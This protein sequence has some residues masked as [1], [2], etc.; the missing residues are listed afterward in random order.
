MDRSD[1]ILL[2]IREELA[3]IREELKAHH[4]YIQK[5]DAALDE[6]DEAD[7][8]ERDSRVNAIAGNVDRFLGGLKEATGESEYQNP[9]PP[10][11]K[12]S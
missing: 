10:E 8:A 5:R 7:R 11:G 9:K 3:G 6:A 12:A 2:A 1:E 4:S